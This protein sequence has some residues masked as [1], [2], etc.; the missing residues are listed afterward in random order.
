[1][2]GRRLEIDALGLLPCV[3]RVAEV[4]VGGGLEVDRLLEIEFTD[5]VGRRMRTCAMRNDPEGHT[6]N[7]RPEVPV[8][9]NYLN[10]LL[11]RLLASAVSVNINGEGLSH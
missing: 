6:N 5:W 8:L 10:E 9:A 3:G 4:A 7:T 2:Q 11:I 1:V